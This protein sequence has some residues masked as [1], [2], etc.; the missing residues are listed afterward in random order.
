MLALEALEHGECPAPSMELD[1][2]VLP[3]QHWEGD[4]YRGGRCSRLTPRPSY[5]ASRCRRDAPAS[6]LRVAAAAAAAAEDNGS[7]L[8]SPG[9]VEGALPRGRITR[10]CRKQCVCS[11]TYL[12]EGRRTWCECVDGSQDGSGGDGPKISRGCDGH[13][14]FLSR[15]RAAS[16]PVVLGGGHRACTDQI[17]CPSGV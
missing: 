6:Q 2:R 3:A 17:L 14:Q 4:A 7:R 12:G 5:W 10:P 8:L 15:A 9:F 16:S 1:G 13:Y 11:D